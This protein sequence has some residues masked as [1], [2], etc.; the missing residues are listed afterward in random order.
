MSSVVRYGDVAAAAERIRG[1]VERTPLAR[2]RTLGAI[3]GAEVY[4]KYEN[5]QF[6]ASYKERGAR[7]RLL[8]LPAGAGGVVAASAGNFAQ[9]VAHHATELGIPAVIVMPVATPNV[10]VARTSVLGAE[11]VKLG[12]TFEDASA[13]AVALAAERG[14]E[15]LSPFDDPEVIAGQGTVAIEIAEDLPDVDVVVVPVGGGGLIAGM[16]LALRTLLPS[17]EIVGV[18]G[19]R[20]PGCST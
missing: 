8:Q 3:C 4:V 12:T 6:T 13:H 5:L 19:E 18:Q 16:S 11:V 15:L 20:F 14:W 2:S 9:G 10:K 7:N 1:A 17:V